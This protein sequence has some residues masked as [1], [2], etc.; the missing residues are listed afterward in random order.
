MGKSQ[1]DI[2]AVP[3]STRERELPKNYWVLRLLLIYNTYT[4]RTVQRMTDKVQGYK[5]LKVRV[6]KTSRSYW[7]LIEHFNSYVT[8]H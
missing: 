1:H 5:H 8:V 2:Y 7:P 6:P 4:V 3:R